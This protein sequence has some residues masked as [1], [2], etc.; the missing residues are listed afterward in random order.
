MVAVRGHQ[1]GVLWREARGDRLA[2][3]GIKMAR[4]G[5]HAR[6]L[7][8]GIAKGIRKA[9]NRLM[10]MVL[11]QL[12]GLHNFV[13]PGVQADLA[14]PG[15]RER[16]VGDGEAF[17]D[18]GKLRPG[19]ADDREALLVFPGRIPLFAVLPR[20]QVEGGLGPVLAEEFAEADVVEIAIIPAGD[21][22]KGL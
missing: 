20:I 5:D 16:V 1:H 8:C 12:P 17:V 19:E 11:K 15:V 6:R 13:A 2:G 14:G 21:D 10:E 7:R 3:A 4:F 18:G 9:V 22:A